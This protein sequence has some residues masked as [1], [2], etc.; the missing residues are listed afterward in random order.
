MKSEQN[1]G[2]NAAQPLAR[3]SQA[4]LQAK[5]QLTQVG[6]GGRKPDVRTA[7]ENPEA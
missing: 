1:Q 7:P 3:V 6:T 5:E 2:L 4:L